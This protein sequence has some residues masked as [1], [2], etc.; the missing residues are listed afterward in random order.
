MLRQS[1]YMVPSLLDT[2]YVVQVGLKLTSVFL[3]RP[4]KYLDYRYT[5]LYLAITSLY[6]DHI[7]IALFLNRS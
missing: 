3:P 1:H 4:P 7:L 5:L 2:L 6:N